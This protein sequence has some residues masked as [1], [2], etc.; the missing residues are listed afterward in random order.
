[1]TVYDCFTFCDELDTLEIRLATLDPVVD[2]FV[3]VESKQTFARKAKPLHYQ[4]NAKRYAKWADKI[5]HIVVD[6]PADGNRWIA[7]FVS[8]DAA[9]QG[10]T[11]AQ[12]DDY[13]MWGDVDEIPH[14]DNVARRLLGRNEQN[15]FRYYWNL[16]STERM[17]NTIAMPFGEIERRGGMAKIRNDQWHTL[18]TWAGG[19]HFSTCGDVVE[20]LKTRAH[21]EYDTPAFHALAK[22]N[23][24]KG[25]D[26]LGRNYALFPVEISLLPQYVQDNAERFSDRLLRQFRPE[27]A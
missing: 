2:V 15:S 10:L 22:D 18:A 9:M 6:L 27:A 11:D 7:E 23:R 8:R 24:A 17:R 16:A 21:E 26:P 5:R 20:H 25:Q 3:L 13:A 14:P 1:M 4:K 19:W 12:P